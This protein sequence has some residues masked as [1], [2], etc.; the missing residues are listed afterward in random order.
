MTVFDAVVKENFPTLEIYTLP[1]TRAHGK[2]HPEVFRVP[3]LFQT[4]NEK[5]KDS[6]SDKPDLND[7]F[8][9]LREVT[10][11]YA[12]PDDACETYEAVCEMLSEAADA[13]YA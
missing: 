13:Y 11:Q 7:E 5:V 3:E 4:M 6:G 9:E 2:N 1:L 8:T 10:S 12:L